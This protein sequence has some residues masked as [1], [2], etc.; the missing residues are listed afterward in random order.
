MA[1]TLGLSFDGPKVELERRI[2]EI[3]N[4]QKLNWE[5]YLQ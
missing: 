1:N 5:T 4:N 2:G 3:L